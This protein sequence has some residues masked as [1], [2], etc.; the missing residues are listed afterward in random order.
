MAA[1]PDVTEKWTGVVNTVTIGKSKEEGGKAD[2]VVKV[3]G[4]KAM[5]YLADENTRGMKPAL[6]MDIL[7]ALPEDFPAALKEA[8]GD[9]VNNPVEWAKK[10][11]EECGAELICLKLDG[12]HPDKGDRP[13][14]EAV[15]VVADVAEAVSVPLIVWGSGHDDKDNELMPKVS[16][17]LKGQNALLGAATKDNYKTL[18]AVCLADGHNIISLSPLDI[19]IAKQ[20]NILIS[21][22]DFP[23]DRIVMFQTTG[24]LGYG[25]E[26]VYS[27]QERQR[28]AALTGDK[29]MAMPMICDVGS[30]AW[31]AKEA[32]AP[33]SDFPAWGP[34]KERGPMWEAMTASA[35][36]QSGADIFR[37]RHPEAA[38]ILKNILDEIWK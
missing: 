17:L 25:L 2:K 28:L 7:D 14:D 35:L 20:T 36:I 13:V 22:M 4:A 16:Q 27:I 19:N 33:A 11:I 12:T 31:R 29:L 38:K 34:E 10:N 26:Y 32:K 24:A 30:E 15:K 3:G 5:P 18:V 6:A 37:M 21:E 23:S 9:V 1:I 8:I